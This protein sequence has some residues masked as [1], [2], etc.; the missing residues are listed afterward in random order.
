M[1]ILIKLFYILN[2]NILCQNQKYSVKSKVEPLYKI[3]PMHILTQRVISVVT[4]IDLLIKCQIPGTVF[5]F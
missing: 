3:V 5:K 4:A 1:S 2:E